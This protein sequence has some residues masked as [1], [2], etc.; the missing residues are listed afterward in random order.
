M[1][2]ACEALHLGCYKHG[3]MSNFMHVV[4]PSIS[5]CAPIQS[6]GEASTLRAV[7]TSIKSPLKG[8]GTSR[9]GRATTAKIAL[10]RGL[11]GPWKR[12]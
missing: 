9:R 3:S 11:P 2:K 6:W 8:K 5:C 12:Q 7:H 10:G 1:R 4:R